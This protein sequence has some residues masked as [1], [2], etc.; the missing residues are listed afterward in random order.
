M[1]PDGTK[2]SSFSVKNNTAGSASITKNIIAAMNSLKLADTLIGIEATGVYGEN[3]M[4]YM[5]EDV[6]LGQ[7]NRKFHVLNPKQVK[8]FKDV[9]PDLPKNDPVDAFVIADNLRFGRI[10]KEI[11]MDDYR[12]K[13]LQ[14]LTRA[15]FFAVQNLAR[16][17][18]RFVNY[19]FTKFS[20]LIQD[21]VFSDH[22]GATSMALLEEFETIDE[23]A[24]M[25]IDDLADFIAEKGRNHFPDP[26]AV[27]KAVQS[28][29]KTS[30]NLPKPLNDS[31]NQVISVSIANIRALKLPIKT[32]DKAIEKQL[33]LIPNTLTSIK[34]IGLIYASGIIAEIGDINRFDNHAALAKYAGLVWNDN[35]SGKFTAELTPL[36]NSG[37]RY[38]RYYLIEATDSLRKYDSEFRRFYDLKFNEVNRFHH[39]RALALTARKFVRLVF[40]LLK[41]NRL[42]IPPEEH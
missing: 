3:L 23:L 41:D 42:Y 8:K 31:I 37:N 9:H 30:Y 28:A 12:Y 17:K 15:R 29:A 25:D 21:K 26:Q 14:N 35:K 2:H 16:E 18:Q 19:L 36:V 13:A 34:G 5:R 1:N 4:I 33:V 7:F 10:T 40:R 20:G 32:L 27:A 38:L 39:K 11:Y 24:Y 6:S 22:T